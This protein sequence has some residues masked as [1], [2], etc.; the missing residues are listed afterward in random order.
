M[1]KRDI[2]CVKLGCAF[3]M[4]SAIREE[5]LES[6]LEMELGEIIGQENMKYVS[7]ARTSRPD[8]RVDPFKRSRKG[9]TGIF[10]DIVG[11]GWKLIGGVMN[12][13]KTVQ[14]TLSK[15]NWVTIKTRSGL[16]RNDAW[17]GPD[18]IESWNKKCAELGGY[19]MI[20]GKPSTDSVDKKMCPFPLEK[21]SRKAVKLTT[22]GIKQPKKKKGPKVVP[23]PSESIPRPTGPSAIQE[24]DPQTRRDLIDAYALNLMSKFNNTEECQRELNNANWLIEKGKKQD[25]LETIQRANKKHGCNMPYPLEGDSVEASGNRQAYRELM[26]EFGK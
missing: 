18:V 16:G 26:V 13:P 20:N 25:A 22:S 10:S 7:R 24:V 6:R 12:L 2:R 15:G 8:Q 19:Q 3:P 14:E 11:Q 9:L 5:E 23:T 4:T 1:S 17:F 21:V